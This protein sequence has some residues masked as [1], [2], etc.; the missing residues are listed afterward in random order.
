MCL[1]PAAGGS[2]GNVLTILSLLGWT[3]YPIARLRDDSAAD[4]LLEDIERWG[5][6]SSLISRGPS[7]STPIIVERIHLGRNGHTWHH[8]E[9][10]C[11]TCGA[12][13][14]R[15]RPV[16]ATQVPAIVGKAPK[17]RVFYFDRVARGILELARAARS[18]GALIIFEPS[19]VKE[20]RLFRE[21]LGV[22]DILKYSSERMDYAHELLRDVAAPLEVATFGEHGL[23]FR[24]RGGR[25]VPRWRT[26]EATPTPGLRDA[27]GAGDWCTAAVAHSLGRGG[28]A[29]LEE[30]SLGDVEAAL[31]VG[32]GLAALNCQH[33][34]ARGLMCSLP[35]KRLRALLQAVWN[36]QRPS[37]TAEVDGQCLTADY[38]Q[39]CPSCADA[40][41][42]RTLSAGSHRR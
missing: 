7:G 24:W 12:W 32:Q 22:A 15:F 36:G 30:A 42:Q 28:R 20:P 19:S 5:V 6:K 26:M 2:C 23:R 41:V 9:W 33:Y 34:G 38:G 16:L 3:S 8:F 17:P 31:A 27:A 37:A 39:L 21:C 4:L 35:P 11:P 29:S 25:S 40:G 1:P 14:P 18:H 10:T 13:L